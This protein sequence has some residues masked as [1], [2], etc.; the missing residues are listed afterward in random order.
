MMGL[1]SVGTYTYR[2][3]RILHSLETNKMIRTEDD[4]KSKRSLSLILSYKLTKIF[5]RMGTFVHCFLG[6]LLDQL[7]C[8]TLS[9]HGREA[10]KKCH[11]IDP[12]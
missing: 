1:L 2:K 6:L 8:I 10:G 7:C 5:F 9:P 12:G 4:K 11:R 3:E